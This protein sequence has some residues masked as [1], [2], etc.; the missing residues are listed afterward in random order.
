LFTTSDPE[1]G[2]KKQEQYWI[3]VGERSVVLRVIKNPLWSKEK[4]LEFV[5]MTQCMVKAMLM[6]LSMMVLL[7]S[8]MRLTIKKTNLLM[9]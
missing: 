2:L 8:N 6:V 3:D 5:N 7:A 1:T 4:H 9:L